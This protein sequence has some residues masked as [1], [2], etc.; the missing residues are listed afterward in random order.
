MGKVYS[1]P[2]KKRNNFAK[3]AV[4][5]GLLIVLVFAMIIFA[6]YSQNKQREYEVID[7]AVMFVENLPEVIELLG[8]NPTTYIQPYLK[9]GYAGV[10]IRFNE[11]VIQYLLSDG[12]II[13]YYATLGSDNTVLKVEV[14]QQGQERRVIFE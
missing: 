3:K 5:V 2:P 1:F 9:D 8:E 7:S 4:I 10:A 12:Q 11:C 6:A 14:Q 13:S